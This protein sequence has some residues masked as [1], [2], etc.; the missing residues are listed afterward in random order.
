M[1]AVVVELAKSSVSTPVVEPVSKAV[2]VSDVQEPEK[3]G[4]TQQDVPAIDVLEVAKFCD[5][6][7]FE[8]AFECGYGHSGALDLL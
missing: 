5:Q 1:E 8:L 4:E 6:G 7:L 2:S 3:A